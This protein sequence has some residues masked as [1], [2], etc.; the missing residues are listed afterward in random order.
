MLWTASG[1]TGETGKAGELKFLRSAI[2]WVVKWA[3]FSLDRF[4]V[5]ILGASLLRGCSKSCGVGASSRR[6][7]P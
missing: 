2:W 7:G 3:R 1:A 4:I 6:A 5:V